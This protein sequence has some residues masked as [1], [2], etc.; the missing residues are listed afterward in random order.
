MA[1]SQRQRLLEGQRHLSS[2]AR[3][4]HCHR[5]GGA[6]AVLFPGSHVK[7]VQSNSDI[8]LR[9]RVNCTQHINVESTHIKCHWWHFTVTSHPG[10]LQAAVCQA[11]TAHS[12]WS[13]HVRLVAPRP[14]GSVGSWRPA[15]P[16]AHESAVP[17]PGSGWFMET[18]LPS[19]EDAATPRQAL[20]INRD[21]Q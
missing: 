13:G 17:Q 10:A 16:A 11:C 1:L 14:R 3:E 20:E 6:L 5:G 2:G 7:K 4:W 8:P 15:S 18:T 12:L 19:P 21:T 9:T